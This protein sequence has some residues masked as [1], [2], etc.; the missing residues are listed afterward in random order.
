[1]FSVKAEHNHSHK[2]QNQILKEMR[3]AV[4]LI[5][6]MDGYISSEKEIISLS[7][8]L[9]AKICNEGEVVSCKSVTNDRINSFLSLSDNNKNAQYSM[10]YK[11]N[12]IIDGYELKEAYV[13]GGVVEHIAYENVDSGE[14]FNFRGNSN[15]IQIIE[16]EKEYKKKIY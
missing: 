11:P 4:L 2:T 6:P 14:G 3:D 12:L 15:I 8:E 1:M 9:I 5:E 16:S 10:Y 7:G 13:Q